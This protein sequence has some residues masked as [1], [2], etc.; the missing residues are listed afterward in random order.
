MELFLFWFIFS[1][2]AG[3]I[4]GNKGRSGF[5]F[6]LLAIVLSPLIGILCALIARPNTG[7]TEAE[8]LQTGTMRR[9]PYCAE[10]VRAEAVKC[11]HCQSAL[12]ALPRPLTGAEKLG[13]AYARLTRSV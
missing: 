13:R 1:V 3:A 7:R 9:C 10:L 4:A 8:A 12:V 6:F 11:R 2:I 5:G